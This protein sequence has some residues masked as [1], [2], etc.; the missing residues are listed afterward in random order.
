MKV[1]LDSN[2]LVAAFATRGLCRDLLAQLVLKHEPILAEPVIVETRRVLTE[3][4]GMPRLRVERLLRRLRRYHVDCPS[5]EAIDIEVRD[6]N[7][8]EIVRC[9]IACRADVLVSG[10]RDLLE[11]VLPI[12]V[13]SP[14]T[15]WQ[16]LRQSLQ[17]DVIH[18]PAATFGR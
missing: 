11:A 6:P 1:F 18:E 14:R 4:L 17:P 5:L 8:V 15:L 9:A 16:T 3:K 13:L 2:V 10:D 12:R 7:D